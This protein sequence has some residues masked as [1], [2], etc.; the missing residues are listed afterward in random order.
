M[1]SRIS[2]VFSSNSRYRSRLL[3][4]LSRKGIYY[5]ESA[6]LTQLP[7]RLQKEVRNQA[8]T[9]G[10]HAAGPTAGSLP[11]PGRRG[12]TAPPTAAGAAHPARPGQ[13]TLPPASRLLLSLEPRWCCHFHTTRTTTFY[14]SLNFSLSLLLCRLHGQTPQ[15]VHLTG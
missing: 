11:G 14:T 13:G 12:H 9:E 15:W 4:K 3:T 8:Q 2:S 5:R 10:R 6:E 1:G 7:G